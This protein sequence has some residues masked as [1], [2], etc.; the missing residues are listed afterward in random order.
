MGVVLFLVTKQLLSLA[1]VALSPLLVVGAFV[2]GAITSRRTL[3]AQIKQ[4]EAALLASEKSQVRAHEAERLARLRSP[5]R[6]QR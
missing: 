3:K 1:F 5:R 6:W 2:D 4:F